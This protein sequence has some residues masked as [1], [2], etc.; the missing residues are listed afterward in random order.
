MKRG[1][2]LVLGLAI[3]AACT[4]I[5]PVPLSNAPVN[6]CSCEG[7]GAQARCNSD[8]NRCEVQGR[9]TFPFFLVASVPSSSFYAPGTTF[10]LY[11]DQR[12]AP[13][14]TRTATAAGGIVSKCTGPKCVE[15]GG[16]TLVTNSYQ[17]SA[18]Q[19]LRVRYPLA[20][21]Q[22]IPARVEYELVANNPDPT[23]AQPNFPAG[24]PA[25]ASF[26]GP[27]LGLQG[28][29]ASVALPSGRYLRVL[30]PQP[31]FDALFPPRTE[32]PLELKPGS[33]VP[34]D[35]SLTR[36]TLDPVDTRSVTVTREDGLEG[37]QVWVAD[38]ATKRRISTLKTLSGTTQT[39]N[40]DTT[41]ERRGANGGLGDDVE[42][43]VAPPASYLGI[44]RFINPVNG[45]DL[46]TIK[47]PFVPV[48]VEVRG[49]VLEP[50]E[51]T[52]QF[53]GF[54]ARLSFESVNIQTPREASQ[55][56]PLLHY[57]TSLGTDDR[58]RFAT[59]L[60]AGTY[61]VTVEPLQGTGFAK[62]RQIVEVKATDTGITG[63]KL[64]P[65]RRTVVRGRVVLADR[66]PLA[67]AD[68]LATPETPKSAEGPK[69][70]PNQ[71]RTDEAGRFSL[72]LD[73]GPYVISAVPKSGT[74]FPRVATR[75]QIPAVELDLAD[76]T[77]P[78]PTVLSFTVRDAT[79]SENPVANA[80]IRIFTVPGVTTTDDFANATSEAVEIG[81][82]TTDE[83]G[84]VEILLAPGPA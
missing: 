45:G 10:I 64:R 1:G 23:A 9:P 26:V 24:L 61:D 81:N 71:T 21:L 79:R 50:D 28:A 57:A 74:G 30:Y 42:V 34:D 52:T 51:S 70:R 38:R 80:L 67:E 2:A 43:V 7:Y 37:W 18:E 14:F 72:E 19:S 35:F 27:R 44:P 56:S 83:S 3:A 16:L 53:L 48:P 78:A 36:D 76:I 6:R 41:G 46:G 33:S 58:G 55:T 63:L 11:S 77:I 31:P 20:E 84:L 12:G 4:P 66:R 65:P 47:Y 29:E 17:V 82:G 5:E 25:V 22:R 73:Q 15:L 40:L 54:A 68:I 13:A 8:T 59:V 49:N 62:S 69:P 32:N 39:V 75:S 60:P